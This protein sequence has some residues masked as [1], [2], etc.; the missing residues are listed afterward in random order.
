V[1]NCTNN[2]LFEY[3]KPAPLNQRVILLERDGK[4]SVGVWKGPHVG[5]N[6]RFIG[7]HPLPAR[8]LD[9]ERKIAR[10]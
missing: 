9:L 5:A 10:L 3:V 1:K 7:W 6:E 8:D 2:S 4:Q